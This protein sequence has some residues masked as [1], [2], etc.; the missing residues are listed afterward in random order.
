MTWRVLLDQIDPHDLSVSIMQSYSNFT[1]GGSASV[2]CHGR[3]VGKGALVHAIRA[4]Q[5]VTADGRVL[6]L[7]R[8]Q[9]PDL[10]SA[11]I[12]GF[13]GLGVITGVELAL[14]AN[15]PL[16]RRV[17]R[18]ALADYPDWFER[19][20]AMDADVVMHNADLIPPDFDASIASRRPSAKWTLRGAFVTGSW[21][22]DCGPEGAFRRHRRHP[23]FSCQ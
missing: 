4:L 1:V 10:F 16:Q 5:M 23:V 3:Y 7:S 21:K 2:N 15:T 11:V 18:V 19:H 9:E 20:V 13:G 8:S 6:E 17:E 12:G 14:S 22:N